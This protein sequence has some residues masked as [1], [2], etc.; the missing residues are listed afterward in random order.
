M[1]K[2][3]A[4]ILRAISFGIAIIQKDQVRPRH[5]LEAARQNLIRKKPFWN[6]K[7]AL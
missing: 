7:P 2:I 3:S 4:G 6:R 1:R 5:N